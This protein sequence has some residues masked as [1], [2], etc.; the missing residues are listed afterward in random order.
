[1]TKKLTAST[2]LDHQLRGQQVS[3]VAAD[4]ADQ[5]VLQFSGGTSLTVQWGPE[6]LLTHVAD[7]SMKD[8]PPDFSK[9]P[10]KRQLEYLVFIRKYMIRYGRAP[11]ESDIERHFLVAAPS[12]NQMMKMLERRGFVTRQAGVARSTR[13]CCDLDAWT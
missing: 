12:V 1:M 2:D 9:R 4:G 10:T 8:N 3:N 6:G 7:S 5:L 13:I 11:A